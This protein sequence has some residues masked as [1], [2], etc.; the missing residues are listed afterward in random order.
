MLCKPQEGVSTGKR[1]CAGRVLSMHDPWSSVDFPVSQCRNSLPCYIPAIVL[2]Q[3]HNDMYGMVHLN[4]E[5]ENALCFEMCTGARA[6]SS[7][8]AS[9]SSYL[10]KAQGPGER[11]FQQAYVTQVVLIR[12]CCPS[13]TCVS[14]NFVAACPHM[15]RFSQTTY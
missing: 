4:F 7:T 3:I 1:A 13:I 6:R 14:V 2:S 9:P 12:V 11:L 15:Y 5:V 10:P 8:Q